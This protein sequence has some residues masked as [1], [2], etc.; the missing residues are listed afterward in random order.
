MLIFSATRFILMGVK[1]D[2]FERFHILWRMGVGCGE[3]LSAVSRASVF[4]WKKAMA[5]SHFY[6]CACKGLERTV[7]FQDKQDF[8]AGMNRIAVCL[9]TLRGR[10]PVILICFCLMDNHVHFI[11]YGTK[12]ACL[13][14]MAQYYRLTAMWLVA[15]RGK[16]EASERWKYDA[17]LIPDRE[18]LKEKI[19]YV[20]RNPHVAGARFSPSGYRWSSG[21]LPFADHSWV[22]HVAVPLGELSLYKQR[23]L[24]NTRVSLPSE[25]LVL[26]DGLIW[27]GSYV[28][29]HRMERVFGS[30]A[31]FLYCQ[32]QKVEVAVN[33]EMLSGNV[34]LP[35]GDV[36]RK[37]EEIAARVFAVERI[38]ALSV[39][40]RIA[41]CVELR[42]EM[43][44]NSKQLARVFDLPFKELQEI[45]G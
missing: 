34:S 5:D 18:R 23:K 40:Q 28:D 44:A 32:N 35:D 20:H 16:G 21:N 2:S 12:E 15:R 14:F 9:E 33:Q 36:V 8:I 30:V 41:V 19:A 17:W 38:G 26:P 7:L 6:H 3:W 10:S 11:L 39:A 13:A 27:P 25:W 42:K 29:Y 4:L 43:W 24:L 22:D 45:L 37:A 1:N 31:S